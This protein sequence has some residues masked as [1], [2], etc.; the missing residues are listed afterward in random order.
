[1]AYHFQLANSRNETL[2]RHW[3]I[4]MYNN[5]NAPAWLY[6]MRNNSKVYFQ[7]KKKDSKHNIVCIYDMLHISEKQK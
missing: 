7:Y 4:V 1:M 2:L 3:T 6:Y 5:E